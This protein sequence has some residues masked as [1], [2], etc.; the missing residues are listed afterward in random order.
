MSIADYK[1][2]NETARLSGDWTTATLGVIPCRIEQEH[3]LASRLDLSGL[4]RIDTAGAY[5]ALR[6][7]TRDARVHFDGGSR[8][9]FLRLAA[10]IGDAEP[11]RDPLRR[12]PRSMRWVFDAIGFGVAQAAS[13]LWKGQIFVGRMTVA[14]V[15]VAIHPGRLRLVPVLATLEHAGLGAIPIVL[16]LNFFVGAVLALVCSTMLQMLSANAY[17]VE[18][19]GIGVL[20]EFGALFAAIVFAGR[21]ASAF[22]AQIGA[23]RMNQEVD[24]MQVM[25]IERYEA[26]VVPRILAA[27]IALPIL[28]FVGDLGGLAGGM[29]VAWPLM[30]ID[31]DFFLERLV[32]MVG[33]K[34]FWLGM[35]KAPYFALV[36]AATGCRHGLDVGGDVE[37]L[38]ARVT[39]AVVQSIFLIIMFD[40]IFALLYW[41]LGL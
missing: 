17:V 22:A 15:R 16:F 18:L 36:V 26:L 1:I 34:H 3:C 33:T 24:A 28:T 5:A 14:L 9:D 38:G 13:E 30:G 8:D 2:S 7:L 32:D 23:M 10:L 4:G 29:L 39:T 41:Q 12:R 40:A 20:R 37:S 27:V 6:L 31:P 25:G 21:S 35:A 11:G 19:V